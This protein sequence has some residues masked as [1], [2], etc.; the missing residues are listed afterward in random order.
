MDGDPV[1]G[2]AAIEGATEIVKDPSG[3][4][5]RKRCHHFHFVTEAD[6]RSHHGTEAYLG[7]SDFGREVLGQNYPAHC[8]P[9]VVA[10]LTPSYLAC[11]AA[12]ARRAS[13]EVFDQSHFHGH[14]L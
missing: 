9:S 7:R 13:D 6:E 12:R 10:I 8:R 5:V 11:P 14:A 2:V 1:P 4:V 3:W